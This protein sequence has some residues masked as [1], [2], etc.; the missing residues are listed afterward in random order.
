MVGQGSSIELLEMTSVMVI[1]KRTNV[2]I[3]V[4]IKRSSVTFDQVI[5]WR[6]LELLCFPN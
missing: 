4:S 1:I 3:S 2:A 6:I 5:N